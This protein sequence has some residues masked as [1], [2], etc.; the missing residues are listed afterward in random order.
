[1]ENKQQAQEKVKSYTERFKEMEDQLII[2]GQQYV[3][4]SQAFSIT[5]SIVQDLSMQ[6]RMLNDQL[7]AVYDLGVV[8]REA[9]TNKVNERRVQRVRDLLKND[10]K[11]G[12]IKQ[13]PEV[14]GENDIIVYESEDVS[15]AF[16]AAGAFSDEGLSV[17]QLKTKK[18]G[19]SVEYSIGDR[20][21]TI[22]IDSIYQIVDN[23][24]S[25]NEQEAAKQ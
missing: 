6:I 24:E 17:E 13:I 19:E 9:V 5:A 10:E 21:N 16:K 1:M 4:A 22:K 7:Q 12:I 15:L 11:S 3:E 8:S 23:K 18:A 20:K 25:S 14:S 2:L